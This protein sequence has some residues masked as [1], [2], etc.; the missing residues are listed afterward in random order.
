MINMTT[1][2]IIFLLII[3]LIINFAAFFFYKNDIEIG[4]I[5]GILLSA[6]F[7]VLV[8]PWIFIGIYNKLG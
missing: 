5:L 7:D 6:L 8:L 1:K 3:G 2:Q 4:M